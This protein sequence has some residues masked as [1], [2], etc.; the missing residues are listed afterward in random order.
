MLKYDKSQTNS[1][2]FLQ[3][4]SGKVWGI[5]FPPFWESSSF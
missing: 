4:Q 3:K 5:F 2:V 1:V